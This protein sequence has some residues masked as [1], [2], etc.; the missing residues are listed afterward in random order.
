MASVGLLVMS[1]LGGRESLMP[2]LTVAPL[3]GPTV[4]GDD[5]NAAMSGGI[6]RSVNEVGIMD[7][8]QSPLLAYL[9]S[10]AERESHR[11]TLQLPIGLGIAMIFIRH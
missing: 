1:T 7:N 3:S 9:P 8:D 10:V 2:A 5:A 4:Q 6:T 11:A